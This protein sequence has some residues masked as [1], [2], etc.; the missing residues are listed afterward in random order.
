[1]KKALYGFVVIAAISLFSGCSLFYEVDTGLGTIKKTDGG[2]REYALLTDEG[3]H[4]EVINIADYPEFM[5]DGSRVFFK[6][7][8]R[9]DLYSG[10][11][12]GVPTQ[13]LVMRTP[14]YQPT[15]D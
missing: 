1:M 5:A 10:G 14:D 2:D 7:A 15:Q 13:I 4:Y 11:E 6:V 12:W 3:E 9:D 8:I